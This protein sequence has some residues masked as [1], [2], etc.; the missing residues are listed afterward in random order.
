MLVIIHAFILYMHTFVPL[1]IPC[2]GVSKVL[3]FLS[4][5]HPTVDY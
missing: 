5:V 1:R 4:A 3:Q 2:M